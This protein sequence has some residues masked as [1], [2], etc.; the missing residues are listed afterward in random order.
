MEQGASIRQPQGKPFGKA[1]T[2]PPVI[3]NMDPASGDAIGAS[4]TFAATVIDNESGVK[5]V[6]FTIRYPDN[7]TTQSFNAN[8]GSN[9]VWTVNLQ[10]F[11]EGN[12]SWRVPC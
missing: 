10:G 7:T 4:H 3:S 5:S 9:D 6:S 12:W 8:Q 11:S 1:D 2:T